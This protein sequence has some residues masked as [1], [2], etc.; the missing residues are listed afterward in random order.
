MRFCLKKI[1]P[2]S[3]SFTIAEIVK[4][5]GDK[6]IIAKKAIMMSM[7]R[8]KKETYIEYTFHLTISKSSPNYIYT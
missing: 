1:G 5:K 4:I 2:G 3:V 8:L 7:K 6:I